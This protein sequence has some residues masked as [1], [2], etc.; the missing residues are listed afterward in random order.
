ME[1]VGI[2]GGS[3]DPPHRAHGIVALRAC[4][5]LKLDRLLWIPSGQPPHKDATSLSDVHHRVEMTRLMTDKDSRFHLELGEVSSPGISW[6]VTTLERLRAARSDWDLFLIIGGDQLASFATWR[7]PD[8]IRSL[9]QLVVY[10]RVDNH[11]DENVQDLPSRTEP[12]VWLSGDPVDLS[13][14]SIRERIQNG[15]D[16]SA[17]LY[18][19]V[20]RYIK[21]EALYLRS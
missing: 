12:D 6:T 21:S 1:R 9:A 2:F 11:E 14:T 15:L 10:H 3:F 20:A 18:P 16:T 19:D 13:S 8:R 17:D 5:E 7:N 4:E